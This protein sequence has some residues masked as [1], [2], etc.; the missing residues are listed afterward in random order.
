MNYIP[1]KKGGPKAAFG[2][3]Y[4]AGRQNVLRSETYRKRPIGRET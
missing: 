4:V 1:Y 3:G 2:K